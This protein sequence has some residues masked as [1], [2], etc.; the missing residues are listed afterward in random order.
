ME[1]VIL[2]REG[3]DK[4]VAE[5]ALLKGKKRL[6]AANALETA[7]AHGDLRENAEYDAAKEAKAR[8]EE[9]IAA[10]EDKLSRAK[11]VD[12]QAMQHDKA[13]LGGTLKIKNQSTGDLL[14]YMLVSQDEADFAKGRISV[15]SPIGKGLLGK[16]KGEVVEIKV[17]AGVIKLEILEIS[18]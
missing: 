14:S 4:M 6:E 11:V 9:R 12:P 18:Y 2:T 13:F 15:T 16:G 3:F 7:R 5:L 17:P 10:L 8:L 1:K